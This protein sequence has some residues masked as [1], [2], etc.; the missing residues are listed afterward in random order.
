MVT[1]RGGRTCHAA[2]ICR[3]LGIPCVVGCGNATEVLGQQGITGVTVD[4]S[5]GEVGNVWEGKL[6]FTI[7]ETDV[8][9]LP[10][11]NTKIMMNLADPDQAFATSFIPNQ[12]VGLL[13]MEFIIS[14]H[15]TVHPLALIDPNSPKI[16]TVDRE[17]IF[18]IIKGYHS[19]QEYFI[20]HLAQGIGAIAAA[21][22]PKKVIVRFSDFKTDEYASLIGGKNFEPVEDN[23]MIGWRGASRYYDPRYSEGFA[24]E[25]ATILRVRT[26]FGLTNVH[27]MIPF[28]RTLDEARKTIAEMAKH[29]L[30]QH[31]DGLQVMGMCEVPS[32]VILAEEFLDILDGFSIGSNDLTQLVLGVDRNSETVAPLFDER[33]DAVTRLITQVIKVA[34]NK[35]K[36][37]GICGQAPSD[38]PEFASFLVEQGIESISLNPDTVLATTIRLAQTEESLFAPKKQSGIDALA[39]LSS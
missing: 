27:V 14:K 36:Y 34:R 32:N 19:G 35:K 29:G 10:K 22:Y 37:I 30:N 16:S 4:C 28:C 3:E 39:K 20:E 11:L 26:L 17:K 23:P 9:T 24:L 12:G 31:E 25:V 2:I 33:N 5:S 38:F 6:H 7:E 18:S 15:I 13:R 21:F 1:S 8:S